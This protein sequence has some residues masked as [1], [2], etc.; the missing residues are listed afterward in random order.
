MLMKHW[1]QWFTGL[2]GWASLILLIG[3]M[4]AHAQQQPPQQCG[5][6]ADLVKALAGKYTEAPIAAGMIDEKTVLEVFARLDGE[7][8]TVFVSR[9]DG[10]SCLFA[11]G[12]A[13]LWVP[14]KA[15]GNDS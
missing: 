12:R 1:L 4:T 3:F 10:I 14:F 9:A 2:I 6:R 11:A 13:W 8:W 7:S 5:S 15:P